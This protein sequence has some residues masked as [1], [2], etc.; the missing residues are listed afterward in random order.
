MR[1]GSI[2]AVVLLAST[3]LIA[4]PARAQIAPEPSVAEQLAQM[5]AEMARMAQRI[6]SLETQLGAAQAQAQAAQT[7]ADVASAALAALPPPAVSAVPPTTITWD[8]APR[9]TAAVDPKR[10]AAGTWSFKPR[11]RLQVDVAGVDV[12]AAAASRSLGVA[13]EVR[14]AFIGA[15]G[16]LPGGFGYRAEFDLAGSTVDITDLY[17]AYKASPQ[18]TLTLGQHK[19]FWGLEEM[20]SDLFTSFMERA[21]FNSAFGFERRVGLSA[22]YTGK[23]VVLAGGLFS[24]NAA[25]LNADTN[26]SYSVDGR[27]VFMPKIGAAQLH[28]GVSG[29]YREFND[30]SPTARYRARPFVHTTDVRLIDTR[31]FAASGERS[32]G[33]EFAYIAGRFHATAE[34]HWITALRPGLADPTFNGGYGEVGYLLT[35]DVTAYK[36]G[37]YD[38]IRPR[39]PLGMGGIGAV[40]VN[41]RYEWL[42]LSD[43][44]IV[45]GRQRIAAASLLWIPTDY[46]RFIANYGHLWLGDA[47][48]PA[49]TTRS[50]TADTLG[51]R[52]QFDF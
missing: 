40:Q 23:Q 4:V 42:D 14:R 28:L 2:I 29:H 8:G 16:T 43:A 48:V 50:Y 36:N 11:G 15:E 13:T 7:R 27:A 44:G 3:G 51:L 32:L 12:P 5:R 19:P 21:A 34:S 38:R 20:T 41:A 9:L 31:A 10:P 6:G 24:D 30:V 18:V 17:L 47:A 37:V 25:D 46:V 35:R 45:G 39:H 52:A 49:G 33:A 22:T 26:N 1:H